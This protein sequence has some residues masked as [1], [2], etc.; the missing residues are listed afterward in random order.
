MLYIITVSIVNIYLL[1][2]LLLLHHYIHLILLFFHI[3][4]INRIYVINQL[5]K[6]KH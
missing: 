4:K 6:G 5:C 1:L 2:V 3:N